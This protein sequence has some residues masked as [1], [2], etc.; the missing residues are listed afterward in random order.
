MASHYN[1]LA[2]YGAAR[3]APSTPRNR[4]L[5]LAPPMECSQAIDLPSARL[6]SKGGATTRPKGS[7]CHIKVDPGRTDPLGPWK[8]WDQ[9]L[10]QK[11][12][13]ITPAQVIGGATQHHR[14]IS[15]SV[16]CILEIF[17]WYTSARMQATIGRFDR[18][19]GS[20]TQGSEGQC[21]R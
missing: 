10:E 15:Q 18:W 9:Y 4:V 13:G 20:A 5:V 16:A 3:P 7:V 11:S 12:E 8:D 2:I 6:S 1:L 19:V 14:N 17:N 21:W